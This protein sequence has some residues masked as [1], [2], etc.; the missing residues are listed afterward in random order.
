MEFHWIPAHE[1]IEINERADSLAKDAAK[2]GRDSQIL[3]PYTDLKALWKKEMFQALEDQTTKDGSQEVIKFYNSYFLC[4][5][6]PWFHKIKFPRRIAIINRIRANWTSLADTLF[7][8]NTLDSPM[9]LC[10][11]AEETVNHVFWQCSRFD[12]Q[13]IQLLESLKA[14][15]HFGPYCIENTLSF[16]S[17]EVISIIA[18]YIY[19]TD[20]KI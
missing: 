18:R 9:C 3:L 13:R 1:G 17:Y 15:D 4:S 14:L 12:R 19:D 11:V 5:R 16:L 20:L 8:Y 2:T 10:N 7:K 6:Q